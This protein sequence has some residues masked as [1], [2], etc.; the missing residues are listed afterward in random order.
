MLSRQVIFDDGYKRGVVIGIRPYKSEHNKLT[1][2]GADQPQHLR[3]E[4]TKEARRLVQ[5]LSDMGYPP[6]VANFDCATSAWFAHNCSYHRAISALLEGYQPPPGFRANTPRAGEADFVAIIREGATNTL[7]ASDDPKETPLH[8]GVQYW[9]HISRIVPDPEDVHA[10]Q[11][12][13]AMTSAAGLDYWY[14]DGTSFDDD[15]SFTPP[16]PGCVKLLPFGRLHFLT[17][18]CSVL[19]CQLQRTPPSGSTCHSLLTQQL[20]TTL[21]KLIHE[22]STSKEATR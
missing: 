5:D 6:E 21:L 3:L 22:A 18:F 12:H 4:A 2:D 15:V 11:W 17:C 10:S 7:R 1:K 9:R 13:K 16:G 8:H 20:M 14:K 19:G